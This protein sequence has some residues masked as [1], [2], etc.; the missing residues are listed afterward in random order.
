MKNFLFS[1]LVCLILSGCVILGGMQKGEGEV[2]EGTGQGFR[3]LISVQVRMNGI[4]I[5][6]IVIIDSVEDHFIGEAAMEELIDL[7]I[8]Y[9][10]TDIDVI[11]GAT[12]SSKGFLEAVEDAIIGR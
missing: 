7:V 6:D 12:A 9:N 3:G 2:F 11:S 10:T 5:T 4:H 8:M 1:I